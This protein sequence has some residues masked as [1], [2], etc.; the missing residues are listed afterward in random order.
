MIA[1]QSSGSWIPVVC[2]TRTSA[3]T[4]TAFKSLQTILNLNEMQSNDSENKENEMKISI[5]KIDFQLCMLLA[6]IT[7]Y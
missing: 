3:G 2:C 4:F 1:P 5:V 7:A 6:A